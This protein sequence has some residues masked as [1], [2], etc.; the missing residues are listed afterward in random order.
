MAQYCSNRCLFSK[1]EANLHLALTS[2]FL[3]EK[4]SSH[5]RLLK[6]L[7]SRGSQNGKSFCLAACKA[8]ILLVKG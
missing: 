1:Q 8:S 3:C 7:G 2:Y 6:C 4:I 5:R